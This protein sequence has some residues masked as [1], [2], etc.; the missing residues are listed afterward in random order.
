MSTS[1]SRPRSGIAILVAMLSALGLLLAAC[2]SSS[3]RAASTGTT[4]AVAELPTSDPVTVRLGYFP[5][6]T[7][8]PALV[9]VQEGLFTQELEPLGATLETTT[10]NAG[11]EATEALFAD[12]LD[13][14]YIGPN[15]AGERL[16][17]VERRGR[18]HRGRLDLRRRQ[19]HREARDRHSPPT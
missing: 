5:N 2:G 1:H 9:G 4:V 16:P 8:A 10:F 15:P 18:A 17:E 14:T 3:R 6:V 11:P 7:H 12:A 19:V 13:I